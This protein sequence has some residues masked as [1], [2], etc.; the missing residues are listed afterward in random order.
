MG[1][2]GSFVLI[3]LLILHNHRLQSLEAQGLTPAAML[4]MLGRFLLPGTGLVAM[5]STGGSVASA[6]P[7][8]LDDILCTLQSSSEVAAALLESDLQHD[9]DEKPQHKVSNLEKISNALESMS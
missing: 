4:H 5:L 9:D 3:F 8:L 1:A 7:P 6:C 2:Q